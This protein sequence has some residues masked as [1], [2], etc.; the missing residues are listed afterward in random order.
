MRALFTTLA[1]AGH[2]QPLVPIAR[3]LSAAG[4]A[5]AFACPA[6]FV[7]TV[8][9][10]GFRAFPA[11]FDPRGRRNPDL[12]PGALLRPEAS[13]THWIVANVFAGVYGAAMAPDLLTLA[14]EWPPDLIVRES[15]EFGGLVAAETLGV[16]HA[17]VRADTTSSTYTLRHGYRD[18]LAPLRERSGLPPDPDAA[19]PFRYLHLACEPPRFV[20]AGAAPAPTA[21]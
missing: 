15:A 9:A 8:E 4:H 14:R 2:F 7:P 10:A 5:V 17:S 19:S 12:F 21:R 1:D 3:A 18:A 20:P 11:G 16:P 6:S 13:R